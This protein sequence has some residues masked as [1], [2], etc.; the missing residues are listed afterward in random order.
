MIHAALFTEAQGF[1]TDC[2]LHQDNLSTVKLELNGKRSSGQRTRHLHIKFFTITDY[3]EQGWI[4]VRY[5]PTEEMT[6]D[7]FTKILTGELFRK[8]QARIMNCPEDLPPSP[9]SEQRQRLSPRTSINKSMDKP[10]TGPCP[11][12][13][14]ATQVTAGRSRRRRRGRGNRRAQRERRGTRDRL[15]RSESVSRTR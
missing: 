11:Q 1:D 14:V 6:A 5:C 7:F 2:R 4:D 9:K 10:P 8:F 15:R 12:E 13:C 3:I